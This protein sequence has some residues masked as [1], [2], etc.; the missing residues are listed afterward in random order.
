MKEFFKDIRSDKIARIGFLISGALSAF[1]FILILAKYR[2][3]PPFIPIFNQ[4]PWG[5]QRLAPLL[6]IFIPIIV[7]WAVL[8]LNL[9]TSALVYQKVPLASR[10]L[11]ATSAVVSLLVFLFLV[12]TIK[13]I[14]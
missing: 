7:N 14:T 11:S 6:A 3:F 9:I 4:L 1:S 13:I 2:N 12:K 8:I 10:M 5:E